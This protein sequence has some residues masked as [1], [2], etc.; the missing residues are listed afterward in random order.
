MPRTIVGSSFGAWA[1]IL[2][3]LLGCVYLSSLHQDVQLLL[4]TPKSEMRQLLGV[5]EDFGTLKVQTKSLS[6]DVD[7]LH[8]NALMSLPPQ[9][10]NRNIQQLRRIETEASYLHNAAAKAANLEESL[11]YRRPFKP[12]AKR[13]TLSSLIGVKVQSA[14][15]PSHPHLAQ[16]FRN[17]NSAVN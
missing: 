7:G 10:I 1:L 14:F 5:A 17:V 9:K 16:S 11:A 15:L 13:S 3:A 4:E 12:E 2:G 6:H 8:V